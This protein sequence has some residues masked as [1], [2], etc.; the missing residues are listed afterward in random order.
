[1]GFMAI[2][3]NIP[4]LADEIT[5]L[6]KEN[7]DLV[8]SGKKGVPIWKQV[9]NSLLSWNTL[10]SVGI[11]LLTVY[12]KEI[13]EM[14]VSL[15]KGG[16]A[17]DKTKLKL[18]AMNKAFESTEYGKAIKDL[19]ELRTVIKSAKD[20]IVSKEKALQV[21]NDSVGKTAGQL[22][23]FNELEKWQIDNEKAYLQLMYKKAAAQAMLQVA[24]D[25]TVEAQKKSLEGPG[26]GDYAKAFATGG[27]MN[28]EQRALLFSQQ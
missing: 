15:F 4:M 3:N 1:T 12:G 10:L 25:K 9:A 6:K 27:G 2:S 24:V 21:Y 13:G 8:A 19:A 28:L 7:D 18:E 23:S 5:K 26:F 20:G 17:F 14:V 16:D 11:M 22:K